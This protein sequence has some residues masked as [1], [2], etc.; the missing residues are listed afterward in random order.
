MLNRQQAK[1]NETPTTSLIKDL[2]RQAPDEKEKIDALQKMVEELRSDIKKYKESNMLLME[3]N[4]K[5]RETK[6][7]LSNSL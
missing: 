1:M 6:G 4:K 2:A 7:Q 5:L 3:E